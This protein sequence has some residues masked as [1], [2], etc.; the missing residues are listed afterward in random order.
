MMQLFCHLVVITINIFH[1]Q[2]QV[3]VFITM[4]AL[5]T[6]NTSVLSLVSVFN[7]HD[8]VDLC[9]NNTLHLLKISIDVKSFYFILLALVPCPE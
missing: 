9:Y 8:F 3:N 7:V 6:L 2:A 5:Q 4:S 1:I